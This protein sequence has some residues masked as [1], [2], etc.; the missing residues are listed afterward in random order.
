MV[1]TPSRKVSDLNDLANDVIK[2]IQTED[3]E[4]YYALFPSA[5]LVAQ[6]GIIAYGLNS[7]SKEDLNFWSRP[8]SQYHKSVDSLEKIHKPKSISS[9]QKMFKHFH[10]KLVWEKVKLVGIETTLTDSSYINN[11]KTRKKTKIIRTNLKIRIVCEDKRYFLDCRGAYYIETEG[12]FLYKEPE[13]ILLR[14][15]KL[16]TRK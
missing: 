2:S 16:G 3:V 6:Y 11:I 10:S 14:E 13:T 7:N 4:K 9:I 1:F 12:W 15:E 8:Y 5:D